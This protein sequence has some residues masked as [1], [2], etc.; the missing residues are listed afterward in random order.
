MDWLLS[1]EFVTF[2]Q[3][4]AGIYN[5]KKKI[6]QELKEYYDKIQLKMKD[7]DAQAQ[8]LQEEF[9]RWKSSQSDEVKSVKQK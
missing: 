1:E 9:D 2:S 8:A 6:K 7:L 3:R 4:V 5:E